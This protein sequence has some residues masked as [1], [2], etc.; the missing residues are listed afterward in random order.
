MRQQHTRT[1]RYHSQHH[2]HARPVH[3]AVQ[4]IQQEQ[5]ADPRIAGGLD[6][7]VAHT[8][9]D[10]PGLLRLDEQPHER[11]GKHAHRQSDRDAE[12]DRTHRRAPDATADAVGFACA[13]ILRNKGGKCVAEVLHRHIGERVDLDC[14]CKGRHD[15]CTEAV[16]QPLHHQDAEIHHRL[17]HAGQHRQ[18]CNLTYRPAIPPYMLPR[19]PQRREAKQIVQHEPYARDIL[20]D[21]G[22]NRCARHTPVKYQHEHQ[23]EHDVEHRRYAEEYQ[24]RDRIADRAQQV[25]E[26]IIQERGDDAEKDVK[27]I[28]MHQRGNLRR[29]LQCADDPVQKDEG[30]RCQRERHCTDQHKRQK[31]AVFHPLIVPPAE[32]DGKISAA[33]HAQAE[34]DRGQEG[35]QGVCR[36]D[37]RQRIRAEEAPHD[38]RIRYII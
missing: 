30:C 6:A 16:D 7:Q 28:V 12:H 19:D 26:K 18:T 31:E 37:C 15:R 34:Q 20:R 23:V 22:C 4:P 3:R 33:A 29:R 10:D 35:H 8:D 13:V 11:R 17:L 9:R 2:R 25:G 38:Q 27:Q 36:P 1:Q 14:C 24:R 21:H 5:Q 32:L